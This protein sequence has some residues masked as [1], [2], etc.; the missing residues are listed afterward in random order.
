L[1]EQSRSTER[2]VYRKAKR[3][4][5]ELRTA[6]R[7]VDATESLH[8]S[9]GPART[10][11]SAI[12]EAA[13]VTRATVYRHFPDE[14]SLFLACSS[15]WMA[16]QRPPDPGTWSADPLPRLRAGLTDIYRYYRAGEPMMGLIHRDVETVPA[17]IVERRRAAEQHWLASLLEPWPG[18]RNRTVRAAVS[19]AAAFTTW[20]SL[21]LTQGLSNRAAVKLMVAMVTTLSPDA[22]GADESGPLPVAIVVP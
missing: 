21:C 6:A 12:A 16:R 4:E 9:L 10:T 5:D 14:E 19:H 8:G 17:R 13:G 3:A 15:Q 1:S 2:R 20:Q 18:R 7:I 11:I 22:S